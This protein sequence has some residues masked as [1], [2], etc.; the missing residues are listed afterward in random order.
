MIRRAEPRDIPVLMD[1]LHQVLNVHHEARPDLFKPNASKY[2]TEELEEILADDSRP[3]FLLEN[4]EGEGCGYAFCVFQQQKDNNILTDIKT[5]YID[6]ICVD[7][8]HRHEHVGSALYDY[9]I[10]FARKSGCYN[11]T[12][13][14]WGGN[15]GALAFYKA[16]GLGIQK[17]GMEKIL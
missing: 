4:E 5:L 11:V 8:K 3:I 15:D 14:V 7:E 13:N 10:D 9:V 17:I 16:M 6:D 2:T 1:L 12:L